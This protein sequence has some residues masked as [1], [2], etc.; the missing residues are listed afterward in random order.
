MVFKQMQ[1]LQNTPNSKMTHT[2][3]TSNDYGYRET[4][5]INRTLPYEKI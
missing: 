1:F 3:Y 4:E 5:N 2:Q